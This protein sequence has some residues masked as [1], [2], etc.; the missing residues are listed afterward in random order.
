MK[1][2]QI[3][4]FLAIVRFGTVAAAARELGRS[5]TTVSTALAALE[6]ELGAQLFELSG[7]QLQLTALGHSIVTDCR[8]FDQ[9][10]GKSWRAANTTSAVPK[11]P[12]VS[13]VMIPG[14]SRHDAA[15]CSA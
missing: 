12:C 6:D 11:P 1:T 14:P 15:F 7:N 9:V 4:I 3:Q 8:R 2:S 10:A 5:R 13:A